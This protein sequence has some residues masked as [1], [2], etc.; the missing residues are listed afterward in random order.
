M[1]QKNPGVVIVDQELSHGLSVGLN[2]QHGISVDNGR[3]QAFTES[4]FCS[5]KNRAVIVDDDIVKGSRIFVLMDLLPVCLY[6]V[7]GF[8][9]QDSVLGRIHISESKEY[10]S[11]RLGQKEEQYGEKDLFFH[12][13][14]PLN[15]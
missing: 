14:P 4:R 12:C 6:G 3:V 13:F 11:C 9:D 10:E 2:V 15:L 7:D 1:P 8:V 5:E